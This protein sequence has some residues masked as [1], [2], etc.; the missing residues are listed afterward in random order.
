[1]IYGLIHHCLFQHQ[2]KQFAHY[3]YW[4]RN[5]FNALK[6]NNQIS[7]GNGTLRFLLAHNNTSKNLNM[8]RDLDTTMDRP[9][10]ALA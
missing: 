1:M 10:D 6:S 7:T 9:I 8:I 4:T 5:D 2:S 3:F